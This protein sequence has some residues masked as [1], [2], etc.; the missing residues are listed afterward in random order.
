MKI[1]DARK[2]Y[3][4]YLVGKYGVDPKVVLDRRDFETPVYLPDKCKISIFFCGYWYD[5]YK[6]SDKYIW[7][8]DLIP[9]SN[10][11]DNLFFNRQEDVIYIGNGKYHTKPYKET[12]YRGV[13]INKEPDYPIALKQEN[14]LYKFPRLASFGFGSIMPPEDAF[15]KL[16]D[17]CT[18]KDP[19]PKKID[20]KLKI[21]AHGFDMRTSFRHRKK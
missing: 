5:G 20:D 4:D 16:V 12:D 17:Y 7:G 11:N 9:H 8:E 1:I 3:Y 14:S 6:L 21:I 13:R 15:L 18:V 2:D 19:T 10:G